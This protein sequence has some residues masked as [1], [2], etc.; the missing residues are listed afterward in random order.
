MEVTGDISK[1]CADLAWAM[2]FQSAPLAEARGDVETLRVSMRYL[3]PSQFQSAP[4]AEA[5]GDCSV[6]SI[7][8]L[9][10]RAAQL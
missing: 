6:S 7:A 5:R 10:R 2:L 9:A 3:Y 8:P 1:P 4:L